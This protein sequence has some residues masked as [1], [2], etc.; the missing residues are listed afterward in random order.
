MKVE[1]GATKLLP[2][3]GMN[4]ELIQMDAQLSIIVKEVFAIPAV[5]F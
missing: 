2:S 1:E 3:D 5:K 4:Q